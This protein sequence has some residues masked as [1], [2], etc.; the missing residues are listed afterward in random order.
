MNLI[1][2][3]DTQVDFMLKEGAL[4]VPDAEKVIDNIKKLM[5][6]LFMPI[7]STVDEHA[8]NDEE[9]K[10]FPKHCVKGKSGAWKIPD[11]II[12]APAYVTYADRELSNDDYV[13]CKQFILSKAT[14]NVWDENLGQP[15]NMKGLIE[16]FRPDTVHVVGV[17][18]DIC[19]LAAV[20]GLSDHVN[21]II[22]HTDCMKGLSKENEEKAIAEMVALGNVWVEK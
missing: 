8:E 4:Y 12:Y 22:L 17:A 6:N 3:V 21:H 14:Y 15:I 1:L 13:N 7:I 5:A 9:F 2:D 20:K 16:Y 19:V 18:T 10:T 11:T